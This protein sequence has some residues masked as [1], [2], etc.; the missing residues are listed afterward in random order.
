MLDAEMPL[1]DN[2]HGHPLNSSHRRQFLKQSACALAACALPAR[3]QKIRTV[4][5]EFGTD[6]M[7]FCD[8]WF[9]EPGYGLA[10]TPRQQEENHR[11]P[12]FMPYGVRLRVARPALT[13]EPFIRPDRPADGVTMG[14]YC[15][16]LQDGGK[17]RLWYESYLP[18]QGTDE[19]AHICYAESDNCVDWRKP[20]LGL[21]EYQGSK[22]NNLI[23][24][25]GHG[26]SVFIDPVA[27]P[28]E[29]YKLIHLDKVP[30]QEYKGKQINAFLFGAVSPDGIR[31]T[32]LKEPLIRHT[33]DTQT[34]CEYDPVRRCYVA[35]VRGW[36]PQ[37]SAGYGGR[38]IVMRTESETFGNFPE[39]EP[40]LSLGPEVP[41]DVDIYT[42]AYQRWP[43]APRAYLMT[44]AIYHRS[45]DCVDLQLAT[46]H[47][48]LRWHF[49]QREP[50]VPNGEA[51]SGI[52]G[53]IY[54]G[55]GTIQL[56]PGVWAFPVTAYPRTHNMAFTPTPQRPRQGGLRL[57]TL[58]EDGYMAV[59]AETEGEF[60]TQ[61]ATFTGG[62]LLINSWGHTG[63][64]VRVEICDDEGH[65]K[66]GFSLAECDR[67]DGDQI[68]ST[69]SWGGRSDVSAF[70]GQLMRLHFHL[71]RVRLHAFRFV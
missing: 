8:W 49:P 23:Y 68:W 29:R 63:G 70:R 4:P 57:A 44:P 6:K 25:H 3:A 17:Y 31:W 67:L 54:A 9:V 19:L 62:K 33:S 20:E 42:N 5:I 15:T 39:P 37:T 51:G 21:I 66:P 43:G 46:S 36:E 7:V 11:V 60:W 40:I 56:R 35:Y 52:E 32:R 41:P 18:G 26:G 38:R 14:G 22:A 10:F 30:L 27:P 65:S 48:S 58:R 71:N 16:L 34:I 1:S 61:R 50:F 12:V 45:S 47:D 59:E 2:R 13:A 55:R 64:R 53:A 28:A 24:S 69:V